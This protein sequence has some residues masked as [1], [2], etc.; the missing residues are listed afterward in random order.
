MER[1][2]LS[3]ARHKRYWSLE[4]AAEHLH[5]N[6]A[7]LQRWEK[8]KSM[9]QAI[10]LQRL[11][12]VYEKTAW[13]LGLVEEE[14]VVAQ[15]TP[16][17]DQADELTLFR[18]KDLTMRLM[19][20]VWNWPEH[21]AR[22]HELQTCIVLVLED[23][24]N[25]D[26]RMS[27]RDTLLRLALLPIEMCGLSALIA[28]MKRP[29]EEILA[30]CAAGIMA[31]WYLRQGKELA[32]VNNAISKY[33]PTLKELAQTGSASQRKAAAGLLAQ[34]LL[35]KSSIAN[36]VDIVGSNA[37][38]GYAQQAEK[39]S[40]IAEDLPLQV[41]AVRMQANAHDYAERWKQ[42][43]EDAERAKSIMVKNKDVIPSSVASFVYVGLAN[44]QSHNGQKQ[45]ALRSYGQ[46]YTTFFADASN[47]EKP[48]WYP[49][50]NSEAN[51]LLID[52]LVHFYLGDFKEACDSFV[53]VRKLEK[54]SQ[55]MLVESYIDQV[56]AEVQ[57]EDTRDMNLCIDSWT[58]VVQ[59]AVEMQSERW[60]NEARS[61][62][63][64]MRAAWPKEPRIKELRGQ[65]VHW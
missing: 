21:N 56:L 16:P 9:P 40:E 20:I 29:A 62:Y 41:L 8:G 43:L 4:K 54:I 28:V 36:H 26:E 19:S 57:R 22:Y 58:Q 6:K 45:N 34:C 10:N 42:A 32:F 39:Y 53:K 27:R 37:S 15:H 7:T 52:G 65:I 2:R 14:N 48:V 44:Y 11:C 17:V 38:L 23:N 18:Q 35:L 47:Q 33:L 60:F 24:S 13:E 3:E 12:E 64:A 59:G 31:C 55:T 30:Q 46:A 50:N 61:A 63:A 51:L 25:M 49:V 5:I 1:A